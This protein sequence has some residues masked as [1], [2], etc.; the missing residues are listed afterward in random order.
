[1]NKVI[2]LVAL[3]K[4]YSEKSR[5]EDISFPI[6]QGEIVALCGGNGAGKST[7][8]KM[9]T[10]II[11]PTSGHIEIDGNIVNT[12]SMDY[13]NSFSYMPDDMLF[14]R[15]LSAVEVLNFFANLRKVSKEKVG[16][17]LEI[18]G[19]YEDKNRL[20][21]HFSK[22]MQQRLSFAQALLA[23]TPLLIL[24]EPTN[25][26]DP[27]WVYRFKEI[28]HDEK[29]KGKAILFTTHILTLVEE[30]ADKAAFIEGGELLHFDCVKDLVMRDGEKVSLEKVFFEKQMLQKQ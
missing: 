10:G 28:M 27:Y 4:I 22:G 16:E 29:A 3:T 1:M 6:H 26:L 19:L 17:V 14:P 2:E 15:Q 8:I 30:I 24:D 5:V 7:L 25:G 9:I 18:V 12:I 23:D 20:I 11:K 21:K 13:R